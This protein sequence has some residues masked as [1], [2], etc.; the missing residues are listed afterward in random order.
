M[1]I[2]LEAKN[3]TLI[4]NIILLFILLNV[5]FF[6]VSHITINNRFEEVLEQSMNQQQEVVEDFFSYPE[7]IINILAQN[8]DLPIFREDDRF[9]R[10]EILSLFE[11]IIVPDYRIS[12]IYY[13]SEDKKVISFFSIDPSI[14]FTDKSWYIK[15]LEGKTQYNWVSHKSEFS[16]ADVISCLRKITDKYNTPIGIVGLDIELFKLSE[17]V[18][19]KKI[20]KNGYFMIL[21]DKNKIIA[22]PHYKYLGEIIQD[23]KLND[24]DNNHAKSFTLNIFGRKTKCRA[25]QLEELPWKIVNVIPSVEITHGIV[26]SSFIFFVFSMVSLIIAFIMYSKNKI[27]EITN[28]E[29]K[30]ANEKLKEY[31]STVEEVAVLR[32]RN[33]LARDVHD[34]LGQTLSILVTLLQ[35]SLLNCKNDISET[36]ENLNNA[37]KITKQ[38]LREVRRSVSGLVSEKLEKNDLFEALEKLANDFEC[39]GMKV[40]LS[41][42]KL[43][44]SLDTEHKEVIYRICQ[45]ALTNAVKHG[46]AKNVSIMI[47]F[48]DNCIKLYIF[49]DG[50][51]C[52]E[53]SIGKGFGLRGMKQRIEKL[54]GEIKYGSGDQ[55]GFNIH[56]E[57]PLEKA[58]LEGMGIYDKSCVG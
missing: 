40:E 50:I 2:F 36:E 35:V 9:L 3:S 51:G 5:A 41:V 30:N 13:V 19:K 55:K 1:K 26:T 33:R 17:L 6:F 58:E 43:D 52:G 45:E 39:L 14:N 11:S 22:T 46:K 7:N 31:A 54:N 53:K 4:R 38:G 12:N 57:I 15:T 44:E 27:T 49:D 34:T 29:L 32:E 42:N 56:V 20:G 8:K 21:D 28:S 18:D 25:Y 48:M 23:D 16:N 47:K 37:L 10:N 24:I